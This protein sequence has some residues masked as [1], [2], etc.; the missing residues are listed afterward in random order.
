[1]DSICALCSQILLNSIEDL[2]TKS[3]RSS[4]F[5]FASGTAF[6][7]LA[8]VR[9]IVGEVVDG[10]LP[11]LLVLKQEHRVANL[12]HGHELPCP[13]QGRQGGWV[14]PV[15]VTSAKLKGHSQPALEIKQELFFKGRLTEP[16]Y[17][18]ERAHFLRI[19]FTFA[20]SAAGHPF[21]FV[22]ASFKLI[23][24]CCLRHTYL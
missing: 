22:S 24:L 4:W 5:T 18:W 21:G 3:S 12:E 19:A 15:A 20:A 10:R 9:L 8:D 14:I 23:P 13:H 1:M 11:I 6:P 16:T 2:R 17:R 7:F